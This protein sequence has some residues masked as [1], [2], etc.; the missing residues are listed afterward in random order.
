ML[1]RVGLTASRIAIAAGVVG[2]G[3]WVVQ[4]ALGLPGWLWWA[5]L[6]SFVIAAVAFVVTWVLAK[7]VIRRARQT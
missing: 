1:T 5:R 2:V 4:L 6:A 3:L 7:V